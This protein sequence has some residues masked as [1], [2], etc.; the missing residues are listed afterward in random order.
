MIKVF[1][2]L[3]LALTA[4]QA[5]YLGSTAVQHAVD[6]QWEQ[7]VQPR[8]SELQAGSERFF[9]D[10]RLRLNQWVN[11]AAARRDAFDLMGRVERAHADLLSQYDAVANAVS[12][13]VNELRAKV[14]GL[15]AAANKSEESVKKTEE[16]VKKTEKKQ[17]QAKKTEQRP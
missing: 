17:E 1:A 13:K 9:A 8:V 11:A 10:S 3:M 15:F 16:P 12:V 6:R 14:T 5:A 7:R 4:L 2:V